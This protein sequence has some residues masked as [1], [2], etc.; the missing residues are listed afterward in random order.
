MYKATCH[1]TVCDVINDVKHFRQYIKGYT[2]A[3][4]LRYP[5]RCRVTNTN[6]LEYNIFVYRSSVRILKINTLALW[7][8]SDLPSIFIL[9]SSRALTLNKI[10]LSLTPI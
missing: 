2:A 4:F 6:S 9:P 3:N 7:I 8:G 10:H 1:P 5:I